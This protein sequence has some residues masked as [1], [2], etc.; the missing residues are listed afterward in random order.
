MKEE[1]LA[2]LL[3]LLKKFEHCIQQNKSYD[4]SDKLAVIEIKRMV[5]FAMG[6][7]MRD[8]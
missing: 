3:E 1:K 8:K 5:S 6:L 2:I 7:P 4:D